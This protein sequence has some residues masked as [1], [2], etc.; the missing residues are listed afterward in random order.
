M[1][2]TLTALITVAVLL[3]LSSFI[4]IW[5]TDTASAEVVSYADQRHESMIHGKLTSDKNPGNGTDLT[6]RL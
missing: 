2:F 6:A 1:K 5:W 4:Q 3:M